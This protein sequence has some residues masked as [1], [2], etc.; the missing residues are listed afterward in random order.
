MKGGKPPHAGN[1]RC[2]LLLLLAIYTLISIKKE[3]SNA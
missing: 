3:S 1:R 2:G